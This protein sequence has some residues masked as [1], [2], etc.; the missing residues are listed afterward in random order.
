[1]CIRSVTDQHLKHFIAALLLSLSSSFSL[2]FLFFFFSLPP[3]RYLHLIPA[4]SI[5]FYFC[6]YSALSSL[7]ISA[8][9]LSRSLAR[10]R[11]LTYFDTTWCIYRADIFNVSNIFDMLYIV[12]ARSMWCWGMN[13]MLLIDVPVTRAKTSWNQEFIQI[14][15]QTKPF[16]EKERKKGGNKEVRVAKRGGG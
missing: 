4:L 13:G 9:L 16:S 7:S 8:S 11:I 5:F 14:F 10:E 3:P 6:L 15:S 1:M 2:L 12:S